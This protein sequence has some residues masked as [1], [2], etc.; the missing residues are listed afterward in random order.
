LETMLRS[1][2]WSP[3]CTSSSALE[4]SAMSEER[5]FRFYA[6]DLRSRLGTRD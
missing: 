6:G 4:A 3:R 1:E 5:V 2:E